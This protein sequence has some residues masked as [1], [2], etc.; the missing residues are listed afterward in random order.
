[1]RGGGLERESKIFLGGF[2]ENRGPRGRGV[3]VFENDYQWV[4]CTK[5][6]FSPTTNK[7]GRFS[8][9]VFVV[10]LLGRLFLRLSLSWSFIPPSP[11]SSPRDS[12][13]QF[14]HLSFGSG[15]GGLKN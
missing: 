3:G 1:M 13:Y 6:T 9:G 10:V 12:S 5:W 2:E 11:P 8:L 7:I 14:F 4:L 15:R